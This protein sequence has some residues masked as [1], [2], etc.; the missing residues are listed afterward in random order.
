M[1]SFHSRPKLHLT[2]YILYINRYASYD[3]L[4]HALPHL[5]FSPFTGLEVVCWPSF[6]PTQSGKTFW[7]SKQPTQLY[8]HSP[9]FTNL[10]GSYMILL[11][12]NLILSSVDSGSTLYWLAVI[13][14]IH[15]GVQNNWLQY[16]LIN[17]IVDGRNFAAVDMGYHV[18]LFYRV[19]IDVRWFTRISELLILT[20]FQEYS[21]HKRFHPPLSTS[22]EMAFLPRPV[23][24]GLPWVAHLM[25]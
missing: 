6:I 21:F 10:L 9:S 25:V 12:P 20:E 2:V 14:P 7:T 22:R 24:A 16:C 13:S 5:T 23:L 1:S 4:D 15:P 19:F 18:P 11:Y 8:N 17:D 3:I